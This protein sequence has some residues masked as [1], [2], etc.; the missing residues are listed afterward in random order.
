MSAINA[1]RALEYIAR[2]IYTAKGIEVDTERKR[3][4]LL[5]LVDGEPFR[6]FIGDEKVMM[7]A[8][9]IRKVGNNGAHA[10]NVS[11]KESFFALL[12]I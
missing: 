11:R 8:H 7:A 2:E 4:S 12:N 9:Y 1:R 3:A 10:A 5:Q 6:T